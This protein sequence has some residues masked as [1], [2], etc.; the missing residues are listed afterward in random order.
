MRFGN[1]KKLICYSLHYGKIIWWYNNYL[2]WLHYLNSLFVYKLLSQNLG[3]LIILL[4]S[5]L[6]QTLIW[7]ITLTDKMLSK[8][9]DFVFNETQIQN[10]LLMIKKYLP[11]VVNDLSQIF[12][13]LKITFM[14]KQISENT[15]SKCNSKFIIK[16]DAKF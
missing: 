11:Q 2:H 7:S 1:F 3:C 8:N 4:K 14:T 6:I 5:D 15:S 13:N 9:D 12:D 10:I 16:T